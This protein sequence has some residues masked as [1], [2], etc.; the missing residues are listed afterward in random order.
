MVIYA[1][2]LFFENGLAGLIV[3]MLTKKIC[4][5]QINWWKIVFGSICCGL[6]S[7]IL[8]WDRFPWWA[9]VILK[10]GF[11]IGV[12][13]FV[14]HCGT[15]KRLGQGVLVFYLINFAMGGI[16]IG[17]MYFFR[18]SGVTSGGSFYIGK[19]SYF[20]VFLGMALTWLALSTF[21][22]F[23]KERLW[24]GRRDME[25]EISIGP[26]T[27]ILKG[28]IDTGNFLTDPISG[29]PVFLVTEKVMD[30]LA[31]GWEKIRN[32]T[33]ETGSQIEKRFRL[34]PFQSVGRKEGMLIGIC[35]DKVTL[36]DNRN[37][38][39]KVD[40]I[41]GIHKGRFAVGWDGSEYDLLLHPAVVEGGILESE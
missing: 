19:V 1:E 18:L 13:F 3:L 2:Y 33:L 10:I 30:I 27:R 22:S 16:T 6:Y 34:I 29:K 41:L 39:R 36:L 15:W 35:P 24:K 28:M 21:V 14:F 8:F 23:L 26:K 4:D 20:K 9:A 12:V 5:F 11:S 7:F 32:G 17:A 31:P 37:G 38:P 25:V 40:I